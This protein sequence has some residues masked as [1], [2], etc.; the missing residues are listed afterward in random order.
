MNH[1]ASD[2]RIV[3]QFRRFGQFGPVYEVVGMGVID[4]L[5]EQ[6][7]KLRLVENGEEVDYK[8]DDA[9]QDPFEA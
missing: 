5:G 7:V 3:G 1:I 6:W 8:L 9:L 4:P 2:T